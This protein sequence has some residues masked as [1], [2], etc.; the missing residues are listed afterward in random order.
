MTTPSSLPPL[1]VS[2]WL[3]RWSGAPFVFGLR[4]QLLIFLAV[5]VDDFG[6]HLG[7]TRLSTAARC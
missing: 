6:H 3:C 4:H 1:K 7:P 2:V 5:D